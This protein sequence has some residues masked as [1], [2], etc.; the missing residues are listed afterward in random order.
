M[1]LFSWLMIWTGKK[2]MLEMIWLVRDNS[3]DT[4]Q[5]IKLEYAG[6][7]VVAGAVLQALSPWHQSSL[8]HTPPPRTHSQSQS[9]SFT[10]HSFLTHS[11]ITVTSVLQNIRDLYLNKNS[12]NV[13]KLLRTFIFWTLLTK[14]YKILYTVDLEID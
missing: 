4:Y 10:V 13:V 3:T 7:L 8:H 1:H 14:D 6:W 9:L 12:T 11:F 2:M 5:R